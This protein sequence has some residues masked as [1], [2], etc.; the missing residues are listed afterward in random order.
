MYAMIRLWFPLYKDVTGFLQLAP[1]FLLMS[2]VGLLTYLLVAK[3]LRV[4]EVSTVV[5]IV[6]RN[7]NKV[8][9]RG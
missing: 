1:E 3:T 7:I 4:H 9:H 2:I 8:V 6:K 5:R